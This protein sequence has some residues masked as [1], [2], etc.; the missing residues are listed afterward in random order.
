MTVS[1]GVGDRSDESIDD[2]FDTAEST[3]CQEYGHL[4][5]ACV[6]LGCTDN[7]CRI[8]TC[9]DCGDKYEE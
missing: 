1:T 4:Y 8:R 2:A 6:D 3:S 5:E 7:D 9:A